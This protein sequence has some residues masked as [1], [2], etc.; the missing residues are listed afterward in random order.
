[1]N[2]KNTTLR[3]ALL[4]G[5]T[6]IALPGV[7]QAQDQDVATPDADEMP[8]ETE[9][10]DTGNIIVV[11]ATKREQTLQEVPV[12]ASVTSG[13]TLEQAQIRDVL[14]LQ[15]VTPSLRVSQL[16][17]ASASS[18]RSASSSTACSVRVLPALCPTFRTCSAS[19]S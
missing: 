7:A 14:D 15:T 2:F 1:M 17:T 11:T 8:L 13:E 4:A 18:R 16:Q 12:S 3:A 5:A 9:E 6:A 10:Q 19:R